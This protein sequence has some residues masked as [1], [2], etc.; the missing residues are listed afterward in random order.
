MYEEQA[1][2]VESEERDNGPIE[3]GDGLQNEP[4][5]ESPLA[6]LRAERGPNMLLLGGQSG[7]RASL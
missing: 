5:P 1:L 4:H 3:D 7:R 6:R 2:E